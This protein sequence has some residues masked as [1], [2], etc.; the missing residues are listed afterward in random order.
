MQVL[1]KLEFEDVAFCKERK[2][3]EP[4]EKPLDQSEN[5]QQ[6]QLTYDPRPELHL[7]HIGGRWMV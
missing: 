7:D 5:Q 4:K 2:T 1:V 6:T 3:G